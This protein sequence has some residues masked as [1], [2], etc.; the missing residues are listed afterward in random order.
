MFI[1]ENLTWKYHID[2]IASKISRAVGIISRLRHSVPLNTL[3]QIYRSLIFPYT[4]YGIAAWGQAALVYLKK[5]FILQ[6]R[7]FRL[8]FFA[9]N[10][11][12]VIPLFVSAN[13]LP[14]NMLY[15]ETICSLMHDISTNSAPQNI[16]DLFTCS[17]DVHTYNTRFSDASN[18]YVNKSRLRI[19]LNSLSIFGAKL[20]N[21]LKPEL[22]KLRKNLSIIKFINFCL[23]YLVMRMIMLMSLP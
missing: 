8:M 10:R 7:A 18:F 4:Y 17:S 22:R 15:F 19:Q 11:Y 21:C 20:W 23:R 5:V 13:V 12:H 1:D 16:C 6:K 9:G 14:L 2:Y 3:I